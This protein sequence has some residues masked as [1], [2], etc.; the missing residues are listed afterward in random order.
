MLILRAGKPDG[1]LRVV[2]DLRKEAHADAVELCKRFEID[3]PD[4][5]PREELSAVSVRFRGI[6]QEPIS[7]LQAVTEVHAAADVK[8]GVEVLRKR[9]QEVT[10][11]KHAFVA[12][13]VAEVTGLAEEV[14][15][16]EVSIVVG[17]S[18]SKALTD[19]EIATLDSAGLVDTLVEL[20]LWWSRLPS[21]KKKRCGA[22]QQS[23]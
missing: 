7:D 6:G 20:A 15:G 18:T 22:P 14:D 19:D 8:E 3:P 4:F 12:T 5:E 21:A 16:R 2:E 17:S 1:V 10:A 11:A 13:A 9:R 23:T